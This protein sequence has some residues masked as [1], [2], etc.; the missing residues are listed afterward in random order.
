MI[1]TK[2]IGSF[3]INAINSGH[4][5]WHASTGALNAGF[6]KA[7]NTTNAMISDSTTEPASKARFMSFTT[8]F[9]S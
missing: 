4:P 7:E 9:R 3:F 2:T 6:S 5:F 8:F 1:M